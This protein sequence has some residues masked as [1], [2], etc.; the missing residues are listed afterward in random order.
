MISWC[1]KDGVSSFYSQPIRPSALENKMVSQNGNDYGTKK[2][3]ATVGSS[4]L[5]T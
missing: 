4:Y 5:G 3:Q 2:E 1:N